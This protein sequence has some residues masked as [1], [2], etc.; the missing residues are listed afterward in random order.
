MRILE[1]PDGIRKA[2]GQNFIDARVPTS[3]TILVVQVK[4]SVGSV[5]LNNDLCTK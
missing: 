4:Q 5:C 2:Y 3:L 1:V